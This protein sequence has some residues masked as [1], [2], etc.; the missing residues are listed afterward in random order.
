MDLLY[1]EGDR[2]VVV[3][4]ETTGVYDADKIVEV[5]AVTVSPNGR[6]VDEWDTLVNPERDV[7]PTHIHRVSAAMV[8]AAPRFT[9][10]AAALAERLN[11]AVMVAHNLTFDCRMLVN[12]YRRVNG[13][14]RPGSGICTLR[15]FGEKLSDACR[16]RGIPL[17]YPHRALADARATARLLRS[18]AV[19]VGSGVQPASVEL[20]GLNFSPRTFRRDLNSE[21]DDQMPYLARL[22]DR[23]HHYGV[24]GAALVYTDMLDWALSDLEIS[25]TEEAQL[26]E[27]AIDVG[28][29][30]DEVSAIHQR[31]LDE[32]IEA[33]LRDNVIQENE[34]RILEA[35][36]GALEV[37]PNYVASRIQNRT[38]S[39]EMILLEPGLRVCFTGSATRA[40]GSALTRD[41]LKQIAGDLELTPV[42]SVTKRGCDLLVAADPVSQS[43][44]ARHARDYGIP[45]ASVDDFLLAQP[46]G[47]LPTI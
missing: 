37:D 17:D 9:E 33:A 32:L 40:D 28:L 15:L 19:D 2:F 43:G 44:K 13:E 4:V 29:T 39:G 7:G 24:H 42:G 25:H 6:I 27:L 8:S 38:Q 46:N 11:G 31:Y 23:A 30:S 1:G 35:A 20:T 10:I 45:I 16:H 5:A 34:K 21:A 36:A 18:D 26:A 14:L 47:T 3:D 12:E 22:A 41:L